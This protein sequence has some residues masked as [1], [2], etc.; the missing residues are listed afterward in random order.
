MSKTETIVSAAKK[1]LVPQSAGHLFTQ[2]VCG[3][4]VALGMYSYVKHSG[5]WTTPDLIAALSPIGLGALI[6]FRETVLA[7]V[8][9]VPLPWKKSGNGTSA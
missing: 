6:G 5:P 4:L 7:F 8:K 1:D 3:V 2:V 9:T